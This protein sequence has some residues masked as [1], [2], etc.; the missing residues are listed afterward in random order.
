MHLPRTITCAFQR[1]GIIGRWQYRYDWR[2]GLFG[3]VV[4]LGLLVLAARSHWANDGPVAL[5][6]IIAGTAGY[7]WRRATPRHGDRNHVS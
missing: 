5:A 4:A 6:I 2:S 1:E 7:T 3:L